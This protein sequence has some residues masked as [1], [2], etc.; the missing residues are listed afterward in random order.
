MANSEKKRNAALLYL[1]IGAVAIGFAPIFVRLSEVGPIATAFWR[2]GIAF[3]ILTL[4]SL[5][6]GATY[7]LDQKRP[8][9]TDYLWVL[10]AGVLFGG[11]LST[12]HVSIQ[13]TTIASSTLLAN[14]A[15]VIIA[16]WGWLVLRKPPK[17]NLVIG[18]FLAIA[19][20][21]ILVNPSLKMSRHLVI[22]DCLAF[23]TAFFYA[24]YLLVLKQ[25][26][27]KFT[28]F[29][30]LALSTF[31]SM[32]TLIIITFVAGEEFLPHTLIAWVILFALA[33]FSHILGQGLIT[34]ALPYL[35]VTFSSTTLLVQPI[36]AA[37]AGWI[38]FAERLSWMQIV[39]IFVALAGIL[40]AKQK[41]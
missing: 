21:A 18:L 41:A 14:L 17:K 19:G 4:L 2:V 23:L 6:Q 25:A 11:D 29:S 9:F 39:G 31:A 3:P 15:P 33:L 22:G 32:V 16:L 24:G 28:A 12:W 5:G 7:P 37:I 20:V 8:N 13:Y 27:K 38:I 30:C 26:R 36:V 34:Y 35:P 40:L 1:I 10:F